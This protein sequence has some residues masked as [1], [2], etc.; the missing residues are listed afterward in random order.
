M[1]FELLTFGIADLPASLKFMIALIVEPSTHS[2]GKID[3]AVQ[4]GSII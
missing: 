4:V 1:M 3:Y 2:A